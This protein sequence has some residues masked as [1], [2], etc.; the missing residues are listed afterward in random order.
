MKTGN[1]PPRGFDVARIREDFP[2]LA[3]TVHQDQQVVYLDSAAT[4]QRP[5]Q[6]I[7][8]MDVFYRKA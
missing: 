8:A 7:E 3:R 2:I 6:V 5:I 4:S 1:T